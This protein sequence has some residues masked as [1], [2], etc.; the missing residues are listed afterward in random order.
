MSISSGSR[1]APLL[2]KRP[3]LL[4][5]ALVAGLATG[6]SAAAAGSLEKPRGRVILTV[7]G[8]ISN[9]NEGD[10]AVFDR[11]MLEAI[12]MTR[13][14]TKTPW[15]EQAND[16]EGVLVRDFLRHVGAGSMRFTATA[17]DDYSVE[18]GDFD[19]QRYPAILAM[20]VNGRNMRLRD[21]GPLWLIFPW[22]EYPELHSQLN[23][24]KSIW[25]MKT[26]VV[27]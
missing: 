23:S 10:S 25:Q 2:R 7:T 12:G 4:V 13:V 19:F 11:A 26:I 8:N 17:H 15:T 22:D 3:G 5:A 20:R 6:F 16:Y 1:A 27:D 21:K 14:R 9:T 18:L 24:A